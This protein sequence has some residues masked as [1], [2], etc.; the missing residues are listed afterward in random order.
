MIRS[1]WEKNILFQAGEVNSSKAY[2]ITKK[3]TTGYLQSS[4]S[5]PG[6]IV[7]A[8]DAGIAHMVLRNN[9]RS[10]T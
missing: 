1:L 10:K 8:A 2:T 3:E 4:T 5:F 7:A 9:G 6:A